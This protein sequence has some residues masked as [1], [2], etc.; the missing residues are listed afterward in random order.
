[1]RSLLAVCLIAILNFRALLSGNCL[2]PWFSDGPTLFAFFQVFPA[3]MRDLQLKAAPAEEIGNVSFVELF[4]EVERKPCDAILPLAEQQMAFLIQGYGSFGDAVDG[5]VTGV[6]VYLSQP[7]SQISERAGKPLVI[8]NSA[9]AVRI[10]NSRLCAF[11][12]CPNYATCRLFVPDSPPS[13]NGRD[14]SLAWL[15]FSCGFLFF[16]PVWRRAPSPASPTPHLPLPLSYLERR[17]HQSRQPLS[18]TW[19]A[20]PIPDP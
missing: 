3:L 17:R 14:S 5:G 1:M 16:C 20:A 15:S 9:T 19:T 4:V 10:A 6:G 18:A 11:M 13:H 8:A 2:L 7:V 12:V